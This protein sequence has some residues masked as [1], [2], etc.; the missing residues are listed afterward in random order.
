MQLRKIGFI[1]IATC[2]T[3]QTFAYDGFNECQRYNNLTNNDRAT[4]QSSPICVPVGNMSGQA[5]IVT[6]LNSKNSGDTQTIAE[7]NVGA[8]TH[9]QS[10]K[11]G[12]SYNI[13]IQTQD[14]KV[15]Y[16]SIKGNDAKA[17]NSTGLLCMRTLSTAEAKKTITDTTAKPKLGPI[18]CIPWVAVKPKRN[19]A[20]D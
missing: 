19:S 2:V 20:P 9:N 18:K 17:I 13:I 10:V 8:F 4:Y 11:R 6:L 14:K 3:S 15:I 1:L 12:T 5:L 16:N 7:G